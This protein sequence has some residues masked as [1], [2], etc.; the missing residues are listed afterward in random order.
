MKIH[1]S[2]L[3]AILGILSLINAGV[4]T[5]LVCQQFRLSKE[6]L[7]LDLFERRF[8]VYKGVQIFLE[9]ILQAGHVEMEMVKD[10][11]TAT[12]VATFL[13]GEEIPAYIKEIENKGVEA[14]KVNEEFRELTTGSERNTLIL[15]HTKL[16]GWFNDQLPELKRVFA[17]YLGFKAWV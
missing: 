11:W 4:V 17:P 5:Y 15:Q 12:Q 2:V 13:L 10:F 16:I 8:A 7:K 6:K 9:K 1:L 3:T 14:C